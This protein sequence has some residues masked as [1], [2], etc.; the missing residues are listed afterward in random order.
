MKKF[1]KILIGIIVI[2]MPFGLVAAAGWALWK[3]YKKPKESI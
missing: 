2:V 3:K 1:Y